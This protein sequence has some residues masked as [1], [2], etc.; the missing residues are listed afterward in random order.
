MHTTT[1][2]YGW[3]MFCICYPKHHLLSDW[4]IRTNTTIPNR[5]S[6]VSCDKPNFNMYIFN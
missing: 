4:K 6:K 3:T 2:K 5:I 1:V